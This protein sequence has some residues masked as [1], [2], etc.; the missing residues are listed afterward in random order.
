MLNPAEDVDI[1][2]ISGIS[3]AQ[4]KNM[5]TRNKSALLAHFK[6]G[7]KPNQRSLCG[8]VAQLSRM[9]PSGSSESASLFI[10]FM[11]LCVEHKLHT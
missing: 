11:K 10:E 1:S 7:K 3:A 4:C 6:Q 9:T 8:I 2:L 5:L